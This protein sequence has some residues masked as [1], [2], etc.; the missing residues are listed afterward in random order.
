MIAEIG[1][2]ALIISLF[3]GLCQGVL[4]LIGAHRLDGRLMAFGDRAAIVQAVFLTSAF[5]LLILAFLTS[6]FSV[7][8]VANHSHT[9]KPWLYKVSGAWGNHEGSM[10]LWVLIMAIYG[11]AMALFG[12]SLPAPLRARAIAIQ[13]LVGAG[14]L[15]F[16]ILTSNPFERLIWV[17]D[18][19]DRSNPLL[20]GYDTI[21]SG[22]VPE[23]GSGLNPLLQDPGLAFHPPF[24]YLGY[25]GFS[26]AFSFAIAALIEGRVDALWARF[27]RPWVLAAWSFLTIGIALG[28]LWAYYELGWGGWWFWDP[29]ENVSLM[30]WL[31]GTAL[32]HSTLVVEKR[33]TFMNWTLLLAITTFSLSLIGTFIV[34][35]GVLTSVHAFAV[36]PERGTFI[37]GLLALATGGA[38]TLYA[39]RSHKIASTTTFDAV[40]REG[41]LVLNNL[42]LCIATATVFIGTFYPLIADALSSNKPT[43]GPPY[44]D[45]LFAPV[46][47]LLILFMAIGP[48]L[49]WRQDSLKRLKQPVLIALLATAVIALGTFVFGKTLWGVLGFSLAGLLAAGAF[50]S[51]GEKV[52]FGKAPLGKSLAMLGRLPSASWGFFLGHLGLAVTVAGITGISVWAMEEQAPMKVGQ[53]KPLSGYD[54]TLLSTDQGTR[55][56]YDFRSIQLGISKDGKPLKILEP[57][58]R[59]FNTEGQVTSE[60]ALDLSPVRTLYAA[61]SEDDNGGLIIRFYNHPL[62]NWIWGGCFIMA[63]GGFISLT[64]KRFRLPAKSTTSTTASQEV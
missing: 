33:N 17:P 7:A 15:A 27:V 63:L 53:T 10:L 43:V 42:L 56:N 54:I 31:A 26:V 37:L 58:V 2:I 34:R 62:V 32:L 28:S 25:V 35:S 44:Y 46:M 20:Y 38:L 9:D 24:L 40:S 57:E 60:V 23:N 36:D 39:F 3:V 61:F 21:P 51:L 49:K 47:G 18:M 4:P 6:D 12:Q 14:F 30:P 11:A 19:A 59:R 5:I 48:L 45:M 55:H 50:V 13:G 8:L 22:F 52:F 41:G 29:V 1:Q 16:L 64:D